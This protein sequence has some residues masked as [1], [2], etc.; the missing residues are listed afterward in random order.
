MS[1]WPLSLPQNPVYSSYEE[2]PP[3][4]LIRTEM[5]VGPPKVRQRY[6]AGIRK[7]SCDYRMTEA[8]I[9]TLDTFFVTTISG[10]SVSFD[11]PHPRTGDNITVRI[12]GV[13]AYRAVTKGIYDVSCK[14]EE[15]P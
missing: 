11:M 8:Q 5:D 4:T 7:F 1:T 13:P 15:L 3:D 14:F 9:A 2:T 6:T 10:G 12:I